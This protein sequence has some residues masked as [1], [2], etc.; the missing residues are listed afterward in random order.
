MIFGPLEIF[1]CLA[2]FM[3]ITL[4][5]GL[6]LWAQNIS[7]DRREQFRGQIQCPNCRMALNPEAYICRFCRKELYDYTNA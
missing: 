2:P 4:S 6:G 3:L 5:I 7:L 1:L